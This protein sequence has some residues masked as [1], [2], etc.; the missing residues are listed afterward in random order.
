MV[1]EKAFIEAVARQAT[2]AAIDKT[3]RMEQLL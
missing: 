3:M 2:E 1:E